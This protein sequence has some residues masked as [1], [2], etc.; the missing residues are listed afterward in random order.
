MGR[1]GIGFNLFFRRDIWST[2]EPR[3][4]H[5]LLGSRPFSGKRNP[6]YVAAQAAGA[7]GASALLRYLF[8]ADILLGATM[9]AGSEMQSFILE[10][11]LMFFLMLVVLNVSTGAKEKGI[12]A[13]IAIG[14]VVGLEAMFAGPITGASMNPIRSFAPALV[15]GHLEHIWIYLTAPF[16]GA[17]L[18]VP[19]HHLMYKEQ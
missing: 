4:N 2:H 8:P 16:V 11:F 7:I 3:R 15:S 5:S 18:A 19:A 14:C 12:T 9:P 1:G 13:A 10:V 6:P 17:F